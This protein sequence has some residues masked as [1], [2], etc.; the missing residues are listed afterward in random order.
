[1]S[2]ARALSALLLTA[3]LVAGCPGIPCD[4][5]DPTVIP[6]PSDGIWDISNVR[7]EDSYDGGASDTW[8]WDQSGSPW[9]DVLEGQVFL[10][11]GTLTVVYRTSEGSFRV[12][13][14]EVETAGW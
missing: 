13:L 12:E 8:N 7:V 2:P 11:D 4:C 3:T 1:V 5:D 14:E 9:G 6:L 10:E